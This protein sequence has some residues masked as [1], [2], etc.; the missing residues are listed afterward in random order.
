MSAEPEPSLIEFVRYNQWAN[1]HLMAFC[2]TIGEDMLNA[3]IPG[4]YGSILLTFAHMLRAEASFLKRIHGASPEPDFRWEDGVGLA[5]MATYEGELG[6]KLLETLQ[7]VPA[8]QTVHEEGD[9]WTFDY[10]ARLIFMSVAYHGVAHRTDIT[11]MLS[12]HGF[13]APELDIWA[14]QA[15]HPERFQARIARKES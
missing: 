6:A 15:V 4:A 8:T 12:S 7:R 11:T 10:H 14:Y 5:Q 3:T 2:M 13:Q 9:G 1:Q